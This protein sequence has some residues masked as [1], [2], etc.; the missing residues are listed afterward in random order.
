MSTCM[1][2]K[3]YLNSLLYTRIN[4]YK[5]LNNTL[6]EMISR[7]G[8]EELIENIKKEVNSTLDEIT[9]IK[10][11]L[12]SIENSS[13]EEEIVYTHYEPKKK[14]KCGFY[15]SIVKQTKAVELGLAEEKKNL[16]YGS[17]YDEIVLPKKEKKDDSS[18]A[19]RMDEEDKMKLSKMR[20]EVNV[21]RK[22]V[23][24]KYIDEINK[25]VDSRLLG[26]RFLV[27]LDDVM[28]IPEVMVKSVSFDPSGKRLSITIYD[29]VKEI[30][31]NKYPVLKLLT[32]APKVFGFTIDHLEANGNVIYT[33]KYFACHVAEIFRDPIDYSMSEFSTIQMFIDYERVTY[34]ANN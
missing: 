11:D 12:N 9:E 15:D 21:G 28:G 34:E 13:K 2:N 5:M 1:S 3:E 27:H 22:E 14:D 10:S 20:K 23:S 24:N 18:F 32:V 17:L 33:E 30:N 19:M 4:Q 7:G 16:N 29:F 6:T 8:S 26:N 31:G 25:T